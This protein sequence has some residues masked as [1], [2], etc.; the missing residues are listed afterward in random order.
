[1]SPVTGE[2]LAN[3]A[4]VEYPLARRL[5]YSLFP[6]H[7]GQIIGLPGRLVSIVSGLFLVTMMVLGA[8]LYW[9]RRRNS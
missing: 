1:V 4:A 3:R 8:C 6:L 2:V 5:T 9:N 7:T